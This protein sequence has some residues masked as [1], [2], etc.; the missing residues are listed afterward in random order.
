[1][2][3]KVHLA[4]AHGILCL[5][6]SIN[7]DV[8]AGVALMVFDETRTLHKHAAGATG[9]IEDAPMKWLDDLDDQFDNRGWREKFAAALSLRHGK[10]AQEIFVDL[11][12]KV[13]LN[14]N[15]YA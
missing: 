12:E 9:G 15:G 2:D 7:G 5:F 11:A 8:G 14:I 10:L 1:M 6:L 13:S 4:Q 3:R